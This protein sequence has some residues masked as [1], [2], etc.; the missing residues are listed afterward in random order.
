MGFGPFSSESTSSQLNQNVQDQGQL[1]EKNSKVA[2]GQGILLD[3]AKGKLNTGLQV[4]SKGKGATTVS[5]TNGLDSV[6]LESLVGR[7][8]TASSSQ[9]SGL[10]DLVAQ[11]QNQL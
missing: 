1:N 6:G 5:I 9:I 8:T 7:I 3:N 4:T 2:Q 10:T 11:Q